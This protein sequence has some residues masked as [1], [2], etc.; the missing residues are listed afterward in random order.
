MTFFFFF[1]CSVV[2][3]FFYMVSQEPSSCSWRSRPGFTGQGSGGKQ[4]GD[5]KGWIPPAASPALLSHS[6]GS[7]QPQSG[8]AENP[9]KNS[10]LLVGSA[11]L[12]PNFLFL[13]FFLMK[14]VLA[15][16]PSAF[17]YST[18]DK[19]MWLLSLGRIHP[20]PRVLGRS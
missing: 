15:Q 12:L 3:G 4:G 5:H 17:F 1:F 20:T 2:F 19:C 14:N 7:S 10:A 16:I 6:A 18:H 8:L 9:G 13:F 11:V